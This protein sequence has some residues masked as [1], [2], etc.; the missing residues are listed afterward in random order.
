M[1]FRIEREWF[2]RAVRFFTVSERLPFCFRLNEPMRA[3]AQRYSTDREAQEPDVILPGGAPNAIR[4]NRSV[5]NTHAESNTTDCH[6]RS[7]TLH[8]LGSNPAI[9]R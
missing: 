7:R 4:K 6:C 1:G 9:A 2:W 3:K 5:C 8:R